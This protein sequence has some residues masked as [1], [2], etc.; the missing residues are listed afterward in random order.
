MA[1]FAIHDGS[2]VLNVIVADSVE[3]AESVT[4]LSAIETFGEP[5]IGWVAVDT[6]WAPPS[7]FYSWVWNGTE[8]VAPTPMP[9]EGGPWI[10]D[11]VDKTWV[12]VVTE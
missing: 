2:T 6:G 8:W 11:E 10:W 9:T 3:S 5:W 4:G 12:E 1:N 7:P